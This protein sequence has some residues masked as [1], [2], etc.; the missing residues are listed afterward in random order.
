MWLW[1]A[2][3]RSNERA[4]EAK[5]STFVA[6]GVS[7]S[8]VASPSATST[9]S[10]LSSRPPRPPRAGPCSLTYRS[11]CNAG[12]SERLRCGVAIRLQMADRY[13]PL[14]PVGGQFQALLASLHFIPRGGALPGAPS[15]SP[16][17][18][19][20]GPSQGPDVRCRHSPEPLADRPG[21]AACAPTVPSRGRLTDGA[22]LGSPL[23]A[24]IAPFDK[25][26]CRR[27]PRL[28]WAQGAAPSRSKVSIDSASC[29]RPSAVRP[30][31]PRRTPRSARAAPSASG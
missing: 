14:I 22:G 2:P 29:S 23:V 8:S 25:P 6:S 19:T 3:A 15:V 1:A 16:P 24:H 28:R 18:S 7:L 12:A 17:A 9:L 26:C 31:L 11:H 13:L 5:V 30:A 4:A 21:L 27:N 10:S 20:R